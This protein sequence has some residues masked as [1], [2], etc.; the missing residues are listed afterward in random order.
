MESMKNS[1]LISIVAL[2]AAL[3]FTGCAPTNNCA[4]ISVEQRQTPSFISISQIGSVDIV[5]KQS[6]K[7]TVV[8]DAP[9]DV[10]DKVKTSVDDGC[11]T[12]KYES[13][14]DWR[15]FN[16]AGCVTV[17]VTS[18]DLVGVS[19][20][21]SGSFSADG[22]V[23]TD[24]MNLSVAGSGDITM[25]NLQ[26]D[27]LKASVAGSGSL[28]LDSVRTLASSLSVA[29]SGD[30]KAHFLQSGPLNCSVAGSGDITVSGQ[31]SHIDQTSV[32]SGDINVSALQLQPSSKPVRK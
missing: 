25:K 4:D 13:N 7:C 5:Y 10:I 3:L 12:V 8:V 2:F 29:G 20:A 17:T 24:I 6:D 11:L 14:S 27:R 31:V 23:D 18:P 22:L 28:C 26:C 30:I 15:N 21:G 32:G 1:R 9:N 19:I 16:R